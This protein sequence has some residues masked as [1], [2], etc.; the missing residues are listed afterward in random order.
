VRSI[1]RTAVLVTAALS[2]A[3]SACSGG[4]DKPAKAGTDSGVGDLRYGFDL[5]A[6]FTNTF[7][8]AVSSG[9]CDDIVLHQ[10]YGQ[11]V[12][13]NTVTGDLDATLGF[14][15]SWDVGDKM[16]TLHLKDGITFSDGEKFDATAVKASLLAN[17]KN[18][19]LTSLQPIQTIDV[20]DP[21]TVRLNLANDEAGN[22]LVSL[23]GRPGD[24]VAPN[25]MAE[26][27]K[28]PVGAGPFTLVSYTSGGKI[29]L[30]PNPSFFDAKAIKLRSLSFV[31]AAVGPPGVNALKAGD[32]DAVAVLLDSYPSLAKDSSVKISS[33][34]AGAYEQLQFRIADGK[35]F[36][37]VK[38]RQALAYAVDKTQ[39]NA[40]VNNGLGVIT[41]QPFRM[42]KPGY[43]PELENLYPHDVAKAKQLL[44]EA[45]YP[46]GF[47]FTM[48]TPGG[49]I[50]F[51]DA[52]ADTLVEQ[53]KAIGVT[54]VEKKILGSDIATQYYIQRQGDAFAA[55][56]LPSD[57][58]GSLLQDAYGPNQFVAIYSGREDKEIGDLAKRSL[59]ARDPAQASALAK[60]AVA[61]VEQRAY[62]IPIA[63]T[64]Q[65]L[66]YNPK[67]KGLSSTDSI[68]DAP[69]LRGVTL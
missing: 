19:L 31:Q 12:G 18:Q 60:R 47:T 30:R 48:A 53:F 42:G 63:F 40:V 9:D 50:A 39:L 37:N 13:R 43:D 3:L 5:S 62:E 54:V 69:D 58:P 56:V 27:G 52:Q 46:H 23:G 59:E 35:P 67:V 41:G 61:L 6:Q 44:T 28:A 26:A 2:L 10:I 24:I 16:L 36:A 14:T 64:P 38:V 65:L 1:P 7:D 21:L 32:I 8:P 49:G 17:K 55:E 33:T 68:C 29:S 45:G 51:T 57:L 15:S 66:A 4:G 25:H 34:P 20:V 11:L 22:V